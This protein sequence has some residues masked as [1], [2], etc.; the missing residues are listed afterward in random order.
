MDYRLQDDMKSALESVEKVGKRNA[1]FHEKPF[2]AVA[3]Q[4]LEE[5][6]DEAEAEI[7]SLNASN[8]Y[9]ELAIEDM[10]YNVEVIGEFA[11]FYRRES[12]KTVPEMVD[13]MYGEGAFDHIKSDARDF[14]EKAEYEAM[15]MS[16][17][18]VIDDPGK[19]RDELVPKLHSITRAVENYAKEEGLMPD[20]FEFETQVI[21]PNRTQRAHWNPQIG[22]LNMPVETGFTVIREN[23]ALNIDATNAI[24]TEFHELVGHGVHQHNSEALNYPKFSEDTRYRPSS[25]AHCEGVS[26]HREELAEDFIRENFDDLPVLE[27]GLERRGLGRNTGKE[28]AVF[29][30]LTREMMQR[31]EIDREEAIDQIAPLYGSESDEGVDVAELALENNDMSLKEAFR[32]ACYSAGRMLTER[33]DADSVST[34]ALTT[35]QWTPQVLPDAVEFFNSRS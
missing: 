18:W 29:G 10:R 15:R 24:F 21:P 4:K 2:N 17:E 3:Y 19:Y 34:E 27:M 5:A 6:V 26:Q 13:L 11:S 14:D 33:V 25:M 20:E 1:L 28:R 23:G 35:G 22:Q 12:E 31:E 16:Q 7:D 30:S 8:D 9:E 32:E